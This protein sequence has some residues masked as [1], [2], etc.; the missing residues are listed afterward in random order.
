MH[1]LLAVA[2]LLVQFCCK[3]LLLLRFYLIFILQLVKSKDTQK[4][5]SF[6]GN[7]H[8]TVI[9]IIIIIIIIFEI[10]KL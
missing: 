6:L 1:V 2:I 5:L 8:S 9:I 3:Q 10:L 4:L 7:T